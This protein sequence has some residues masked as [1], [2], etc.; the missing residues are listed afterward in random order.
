[1]L[2]NPQPLSKW[3]MRLSILDKKSMSGVCQREINRKMRSAK[4][5]SRHYNSHNMAGKF[6]PFH[7]DM[8]IMMIMGFNGI[9]DPQMWAL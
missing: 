2:W 3:K 4:F 8:K 1:M 6:Q 7:V 5:E 9:G